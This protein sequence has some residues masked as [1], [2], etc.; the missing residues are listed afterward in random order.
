VARYLSDYFDLLHGIL[1]RHG[2]TTDKFMGDAIMAFW[3]A[4]RPDAN[5]ALNAVRAVLEGRDR[6][7]SLNRVWKAEGRPEFH[8]TFGLASGPVV[9]GNVGARD[10]L[11]YTVLGN[12]VNV[13]SRCV[14]LGR[15]LGCSI[16]ALESVATASSGEIEWRRL[17]PVSIRGIRQPRMVC[18]P[19]GVVGEVAADVLA[20]RQDYERALD[21]YLGKDLGRALELLER[22]TADRPGQPSVLYL[23]QRCRELRQGVGGEIH[24]EML[25]FK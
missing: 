1:V 18:E 24:T 8:T 21:A 16:L 9:V 2:G 3:G 5:H 6:L 20:F 22:L 7:E 23:L 10:R 14:G 17:G 25:S 13:A 19:L 15:Q 4:P 11:N 12:T